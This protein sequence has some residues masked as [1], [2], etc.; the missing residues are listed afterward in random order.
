M[1]YEFQSTLYRTQWEMH[2]AIAEAYMNAGGIN[3]EKTIACFFTEYTDKEL[4]DEAINF[5][6]AELIKALYE[7]RSRLSC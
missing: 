3:D 1:A 5:D 2:Q 4:A 6:R 7:M